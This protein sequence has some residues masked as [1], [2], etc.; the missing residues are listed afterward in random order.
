MLEYL[1]AA[2]SS[3]PEQ[4]GMTWTSISCGSW[5]DWALNPRASGNFLGID[6]AKRTARIYDS[7]RARFTVTTSRNTG[8]AV[9]KAL[10]DPD[11]TANKQ[12]FLSDFT[13]SSL[14]IVEELERQTGQKWDLDWRDSAPEVARL[15]EQFDAGDFNATYGLLALSF[16]ADVDVG[17]D[18]EA[19]QEIWNDRLSLPKVGLEEV[20]ADAIKL[21]ET[22]T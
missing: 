1:I 17:Y 20:V 6:V 8:F 11:L 12:I 10:L 15:R 7:G 19:E 16:S 9:A 22:R 21:G 18:F 14:S 2:C 4:H 5:L 3:P 13:T